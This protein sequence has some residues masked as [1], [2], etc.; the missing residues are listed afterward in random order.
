MGRAN[1]IGENVIRRAV[2]AFAHDALAP[3]NCRGVV[4]ALLSQARDLAAVLPDPL[5]FTASHWIDKLAAV[6]DTPD[7][8]SEISQRALSVVAPLLRAGAGAVGLDTRGHPPSGDPDALGGELVD[9]LTADEM[10]G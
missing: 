9:D 2:A 7:V 6:A 5:P 8:A 3:E 1:A 4:R 10:A